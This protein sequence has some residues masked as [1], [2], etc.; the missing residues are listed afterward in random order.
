VFAICV[1]A[2][3]LA[4]AGC[5]QSTSAGSANTERPTVNVP[6]K[7]ASMA[8]AAPPEKGSVPEHRTMPNLVGTGL[9]Q[10]QDRLQALTGN[11]VFVTSSHDATGQNRHQ[12]V[13]SNWKV[14]SQNIAPGTP[15]TAGDRIDF[16][17]VKLS[18]SCP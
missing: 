1:T 12:V 2:S 18:E 8:A 11:P 4:I 5:Q 13:D 3:A 16:G 7:S 14:C 9:Q 6:E 10:A 15:F 17:A